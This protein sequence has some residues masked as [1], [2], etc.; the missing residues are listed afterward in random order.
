MSKLHE[1]VEQVAALGHQFF[2]GLDVDF[3]PMPGTT[4]VIQATLQD[5]EEL[6]I[7]LTMSDDQ[8]LCICYLWDESEVKPETR[9]EMLEA[10]LDMNIPMPLSSFSRIEGKYAVFGAMSL[11]S[12]AIDIALEVVTLSDN[13]IDAIE[14]MS[15]YL[16]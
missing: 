8:L 6:P 9:T 1:M 16:N 4:E 3:Q 11:N 14:A 2:G 15:E 5:R 7:F 12:S 10:M 13:A